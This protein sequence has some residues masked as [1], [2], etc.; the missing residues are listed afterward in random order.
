MLEPTWAC[1]GCNTNNRA[2]TMA[3]RRC[4]GPARSTTS[5]RA[6]VADPEVADQ[7]GQNLPPPPPQPAAAPVFGPPG[8]GYPPAPYDYV[9]GAL[10]PP[11]AGP[12]PSR[13]RSGP[14]ASLVGG[15]VVLLALTMIGLTAA[16][17]GPAQ[18][19]RTPGA[20]PS[21]TAP[22]DP[23]YPPT[24]APPIDPPT[25]PDGQPGGYQRTS[26]PGGLT[27]DIPAGWQPGTG[28]ANGTVEAPDPADATVFL[29]YGAIA[30]PNLPL[31]DYALGGER[32][33]PNIQD[34]YHR[35]HLR[36]VSY[37]GSQQAVDWEFTFWKKG[38]PK[39]ARSRYWLA[40]GQMY[41]IYVSAPIA[42]WSEIEPILNHA[43]ATA[44]IP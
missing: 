44:A 18:A 10:P 23:T 12:A 24:T 21:A 16:H 37:L 7:I 5:T 19:G 2:E 38:L 8:G 22:T 39:H 42:K 3:C 33:N 11:P 43:L 36:T 40:N 25:T 41:I 14:V 29:R 9:A 4:G 35:V 34:H 15:A 1:A 27:L 17:S 32:G 31:M 26:G 13:R 28:S 20:G 6:E 30:P